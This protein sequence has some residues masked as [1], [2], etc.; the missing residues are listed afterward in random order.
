[1]TTFDYRPPSAIPLSAVIVAAS[2]AIVNAGIAVAGGAM[3][4]D[5]SL[6]GVQPIAYLTLTVVAAIA[7]AVGWHLVNRL[8]RRPSRVLRWLVPTFLALSF[9]PDI[10]M[11][12]LFGWPYAITLAC[13]HVAT[14]AI[15]VAVY[16]RVLPL[17]DRTE[18]SNKLPEK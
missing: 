9:I 4:V 15:G 13:M 7:G 12:V 16:R 10:L 3:G 11:G 17:R 1:M 6:P 8:A 2:A 14:L 5:S 18:S